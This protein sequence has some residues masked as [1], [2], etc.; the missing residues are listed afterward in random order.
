MTIRHDFLGIE[1]HGGNESPPVAVMRL[2][3]AAC[4]P[5]GGVYDA[6]A[7][8]LRTAI[9]MLRSIGADLSGHEAA[10]AALGG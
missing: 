3:G 7:E 1:R 5:N 9:P 8:D 4:A 6:T 2:A 10:L